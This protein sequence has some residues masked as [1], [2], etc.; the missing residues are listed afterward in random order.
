MIDMVQELLDFARGKSSLQRV[1]YPARAV[2]DE[3]DDLFLKSLPACIE[4]VRE[5]DPCPD[6][7][8]DLG[9]FARV[10]MNLAKNS[11]EA[12][13]ASGTLKIE[14][15]HQD[16]MAVYRIQ[17][18]GHGIP[19]E[20]LPKIFEPFVSHG[21]SDGTGLGLAI[22]KSVAEAHQGSIRVESEPG[23]G[24]TMEVRIPVIAA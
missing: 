10:L 20:L 17:D 12:M 11:V 16:G 24:T 14:L 21:K 2:V 6:V 22:A 7:E 1:R 3:V 23:H 15:H 18:T 13:K 9:R 4:V 5:I 8:V 19:P